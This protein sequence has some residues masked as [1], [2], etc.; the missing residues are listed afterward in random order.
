ML[1]GPFVLDI[2]SASVNR[3]ED[4]R[5]IEKASLHQVLPPPGSY[6]VDIRTPTRVFSDTLSVD[7]EELMWSYHGEEE[8]NT[9][10]FVRKTGEGA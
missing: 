3:K 9:I 2:A 5:S 8:T 4:L 7:H 1:H 6:L 10:E